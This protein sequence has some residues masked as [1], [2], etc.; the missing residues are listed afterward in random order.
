M[1]LAIQSAPGAY[2]RPLPVYLGHKKLGYVF[3][4]H[5]NKRVLYR[6]AATGIADIEAA[7]AKGQTWRSVYYK[8][9]TAGA[10]SLTTLWYDM[11]PNQ[12]NPAPPSSPYSGTALTARS[13]NDTMIG[14]IRH[15]GNVGSSYK[16]ISSINTQLISASTGSVLLWYDRVIAYDNNL[17]SASLQSFTNTVTAPRY[18]TTGDGGL[19]ICV[20]SITGTGTGPV[21][22]SALSYVNDSG[23][24]N[25]A[26][27]QTN[28]ASVVASRSAFSSTYGA[29]VVFP[30][31]TGGGSAGAWVELA[32]GDMGVHQVNSITWSAAD[33]TNTTCVFLA[34]ELA[35]SVAPISA[36]SWTVEQV[37]AFMNYERIVDG[38]YISFMEWATQASGTFEG[39]IEFVWT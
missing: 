34:R 10:G 32:A 9:N 28:H 2:R 8:P 3:D 14:C 17:Y 24:T 6:T 31:T 19:Q 11:Y 27:I 33:G 35:I 22:L 5:R 20:T 1:K 38:A 37:T 15:G 16:Q 4:D 13:F 39:Q 36:T 7:F 21:T 26:P 18:N 23:T 12:G 30:F 25:S 29:E